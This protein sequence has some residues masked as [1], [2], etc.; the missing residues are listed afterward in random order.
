MEAAWKRDVRA[1]GRVALGNS[2]I[3]KGKLWLGSMSLTVMSTNP[4]YLKRHARPV[5]IQSFFEIALTGES[6]SLAVHVNQP[7]WQ[8][9]QLNQGLIREKGSTI[10]SVIIGFNCQWERRTVGFQE[11]HRWSQLEPAFLLW[12]LQA[13]WRCWIGELPNIPE[14]RGCFSSELSLYWYHN[15][16]SSSNAGNKV[17]FM[18]F[19]T[20]TLITRNSWGYHSK[21]Q[22]S[23]FWMRHALRLSFGG[24]AT[25]KSAKGVQ[26]SPTSSQHSCARK[27]PV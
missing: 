21:V 9:D 2:F 5:F 14:K 18:I 11:T 26:I 1:A 15:K 13:Q 8:K 25:N 24:L 12:S 23:T 17:A 27:S 19:R 10:V 20:E 7:K 22:M 3:Q 16:E 6:P 4:R